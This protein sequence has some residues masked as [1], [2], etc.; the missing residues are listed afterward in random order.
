MQATSFLVSFFQIFIGERYCPMLS[1]T[2]EGVN[3]W[4]V[5]TQLFVS[6]GSKQSDNKA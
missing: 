6:Y 5:R 2:T 1:P 4:K 3:G